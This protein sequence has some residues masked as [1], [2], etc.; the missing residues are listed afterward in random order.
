[1]DKVVKLTHNVCRGSSGS[2]PAMLRMLAVR[3]GMMYRPPADQQHR[4]RGRRYCHRV[5][6]I[7]AASN[8]AL[9]RD[10]DIGAR[11]QVNSHGI[12][13]AL[14]LGRD[15]AGAQRDA[16]PDQHGPTRTLRT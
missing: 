7:L 12:S 3:N 10:V 13:A 15:R 6:A 5:Q 14:F 11:E 9:K 8:R 16:E 2:P 1:M 4:S